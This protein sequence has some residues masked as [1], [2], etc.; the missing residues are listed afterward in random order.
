[1]LGAPN[2]QGTINTYRKRGLRY[3]KFSV[4]KTDPGISSDF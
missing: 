3:K 4:S 2:K 1:M